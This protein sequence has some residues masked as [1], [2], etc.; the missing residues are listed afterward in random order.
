MSGLWRFTHLVSLPKPRP[1]FDKA[2]LSVIEGALLSIAE[3]ALLSVGEGLRANG[4]SEDLTDFF[5]IIACKTAP[6]IM[7]AGA[8]LMSGFTRFHQML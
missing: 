1:S 3:G 5:R 8:G 7:N 2:L 6:V 4:I